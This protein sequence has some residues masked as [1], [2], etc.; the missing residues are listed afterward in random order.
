MN[1]FFQAIGRMTKDMRQHARVL[2]IHDARM[3]KLLAESRNVFA[4]QEEQALARSRLR[5]CVSNAPSSDVVPGIAVTAEDTAT[6]HEFLAKY[7]NTDIPCSEKE[8]ASFQDFRAA[9][10]EMDKIGAEHKATKRE[11]ED[12][13][14][15]PKMKWFTK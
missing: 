3:K 11:A 2:A 14:M 10:A 7:A 8:F 9:V 4:D 15:T 13:L 6:T 1:A 5:W 12:A